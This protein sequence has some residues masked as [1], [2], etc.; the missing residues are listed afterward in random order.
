MPKDK[1]VKK[2]VAIALAEG[3]KYAADSIVSRTIL[4]RKAGTLTLF[5][6]AAGQSL[7]EHTAPFDA[8]VQVLDGEADL[9][10]GGRKVKAAAGEMVIMPANVPHAVLARKRFKMLLI[11]IR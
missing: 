11:M 5:T 8:A 4:S 10:I 9:T 1:A 2:G 7:S 6:F 3:V